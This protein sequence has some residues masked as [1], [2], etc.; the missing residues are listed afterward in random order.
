MRSSLF[1]LFRR[2]RKPDFIVVGAAKAG[3]TT[4]F[5][6]LRRDSR[7]FLPDRKELFFFSKDSVY[8]KGIGWYCDQFATARASQL[9]GEI[10][11]SYTVWP[12]YS[13]ALPR[14]KRHLPRARLI[15]I[16]RN[17]VDRAW[18]H[19]R[20]VNGTSWP[21]GDRPPDD[22]GFAQPSEYMTQIRRILE[23][24]DRAQLLPL[25]FDDLVRDP[26][27]C[28]SEIQRFIG[29]EERNLVKGKTVHANAA[30]D[31]LDSGN[32]H[33]RTGRMPSTELRLQLNRRFE[34]TLQDLESFLNRDL[35]M[36]RS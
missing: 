36:W 19:Y 13:E 27:S 22:E 28:C 4:L 35:T 12:R 29:L 6:Y 32:G 9:C 33:H 17:P 23:F 7:V 31:L 21:L 14:I 3:T 8:E 1:N 15:Y 16:M 25:L 26:Q 30:S 20:M 5:D 2:G 11:P 24:F 10:T 18:S 34:P